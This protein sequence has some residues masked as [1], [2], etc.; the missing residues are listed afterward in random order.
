[1]KE[2]Q[3]CSNSSAY[4]NKD[5]KVML[6]KQ[7]APLSTYYSKA[8]ALFSFPILHLISVLTSCTDIYFGGIYLE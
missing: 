1:M 8:T 3:N 4:T 6:Y 7:P 5:K 2:K